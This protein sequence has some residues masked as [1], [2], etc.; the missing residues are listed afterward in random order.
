MREIQDD[1][2]EDEWCAKQRVEVVG[3]LS[4]HKLGSA[5][6]GDWPAWHVA[7]VAAVWAVESLKVPGAVGWWAISGDLPTD[8]T[9]C[10]G[11]RSPRQ[12]IREFG[13]K[14]LNAARQWEK[15]ER[16]ADWGL[17]SGELESEVAPMLMERAKLL[18]AWASDDSHWDFA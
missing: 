16:L 13:Q 3:Y 7:P 6:V 2:D 5:K 18:L 4:R 1:P 15:G 9:T 17:G 10:C 8:Y 12:A 11:D 14:W